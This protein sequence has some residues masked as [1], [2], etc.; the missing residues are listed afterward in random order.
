MRSRRWMTG[1]AG[2]SLALTLTAGATPASA[3]ASSSKTVITL[4]MANC[5]GCTVTP[6]QAIA[7]VDAHGVIV[8]TPVVHTYPLA[9]FR[10]GKAVVTVPSANTAGLSFV[11]EGPHHEALPDANA[12]AVLRY[13]GHVAGSTVNRTD[14]LKA[15][16]GSWCWSGTAKPAATIH[17]TRH[18]FRG[19]GLNGA[20]ETFCEGGATTELRVWAGPN[21]QRIYQGGLG[22]Q[23]QPYCETSVHG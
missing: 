4:T 15:K 7:K 10:H 20:T 14:A 6:T 8:G 5:A 16:A 12:V 11:M 9:T 3:G 17:L 18:R 19:A 21:M 13:R 2:L 22:T 23:E 1:A